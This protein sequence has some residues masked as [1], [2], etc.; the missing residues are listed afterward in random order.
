MYQFYAHFVRGSSQWLQPL[1]NLVVSSPPKKPI[2]WDGAH[3]KHFEESIDALADAT[4]LA[5]PDPDADTELV[6]YARGNSMWCVLQQA[7][8]WGH[9][10]SSLLVE[11]LDSGTKKL[12]C[13]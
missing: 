7:K 8:K 3:I 5:F 9:D 4:Q 6:I 11:R 2:L 10:S 1:Y 12:I 13:F